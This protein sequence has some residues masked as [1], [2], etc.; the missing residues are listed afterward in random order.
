MLGIIILISQSK[1]Y[2]QEV[3]KIMAYNIHRGANATIHR[4]SN[5]SN[6][7]AFLHLL[8]GKQACLPWSIPHF[9]LR[10][11]IFPLIFPAQYQDVV[12]G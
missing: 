2:S 1:T 3:V 5:C 7:A 12:L 8:Y 4:L 10:S 6:R 9:G 11:P